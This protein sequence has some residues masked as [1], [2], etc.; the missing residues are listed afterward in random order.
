MLD[1]SIDKN[2]SIFYDPLL[3]LYHCKVSHLWSVCYVVVAWPKFS[4]LE[5]IIVVEWE[6]ICLVS[7]NSELF[8][9]F[10]FVLDRNKC[11]FL[12]S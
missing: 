10:S 7:I 3:F 4:R 2:D 1:D 11:L 9:A 12:C 8:W 6:K 5:D